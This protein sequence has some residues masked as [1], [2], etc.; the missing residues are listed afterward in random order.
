MQ[1]GVPEY[2]TWRANDL[3]DY[4]I[5]FSLS[6]LDKPKPDAWSQ[7]PSD[8]AVSFDIVLVGLKHYTF[9]K[10]QR[11]EIYMYICVKLALKLGL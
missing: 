10:I 8:S 4:G 9:W 11:M 3:N 6:K 7:M 1:V 2:T 5:V